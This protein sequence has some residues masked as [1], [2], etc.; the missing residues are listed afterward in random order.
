VAGT[1]ARGVLDG[2]VKTIALAWCMPAPDAQ[3]KG[4]GVMTNKTTDH[5]SSFP[6]KISTYL[7][8]G[9]PILKR[10]RAYMLQLRAA[11][12]MARLADPQ[13]RLLG[14]AGPCR[15]VPALSEGSRILGPAGRLWFGVALIVAPPS[16]FSNGRL[17]QLADLENTDAA[18]L[19]SDLPIGC[20]F[21]P[22]F[23]N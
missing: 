17:S 16:A 15:V 13:L 1:A 7:D 10:A 18:I 22:G 9:T 6:K 8:H 3:A 20:V 14:I 2:S 21:G 5:R 19:S 4:G 12:S 11:G 23:Q